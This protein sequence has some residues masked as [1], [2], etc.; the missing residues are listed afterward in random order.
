M[1]EGTYPSP[2]SPFDLY[3]FVSDADRDVLLDRGMLPW[4][5]HAHLTVR[6]LRPLSSV[7]LFG[8]QRLLGHHPLLFHL[9]SFLWWAAAALSVRSLFRRVLPPRAAL[10]ATFI[11]ALAPCH[12]LPLIWLA[13]RDVLVSIVFG[14]LALS[15]LV[16]LRESGRAVHAAVAALLFGVSLLGG[17]YALSFGGYALA[18]AVTGRKRGALWT[19]ALTV[20][21]FAVPAAAYL[22]VRARLGYGTEG[23]GMYHD[24]L[25]DPVAFLQRMPRRLVTLL[26]EGWLTFDPDTVGPKTSAWLLGASLLLGVIILAVPLRRTLARLRGDPRD[27]AVWLLVGSLLALAPVLA[28]G[29]A[30]RVLGASLVGVAAIVGLI[31]DHVWFPAVPE[32]PTRGGVLT[33]LVALALGFAHFV[34]GPTTAWVASRICRNEALSFVKHAAALSARIPEPASSEV[35]LVRGMGGSLFVLPYALDDT[36][37]PPARWRMLGLTGHML[38]IRRDARTIDV[39]VPRDRSLFP[40][41]EGDLFRGDGPHYAPGDTVAIPGM[42]VTI[43]E[44]GEAGP[45]RVRF[46][47][48]DALESPNR[49]WMEDSN[50]GIHEVVLPEPGFGKPFDP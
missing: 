3:N 23:S 24:P 45:H 13:N 31:L 19:R 26:G 30:P 11:F 5:T 28:V 16:R 2:R 40:S 6:F 15:A 17:E 14:V 35:V 1:I 10:M 33:G 25:R 47:F 43:L 21:S 7:L 41:G 29:P 38:V 8:E 22:V 36:G 50:D 46:E 9:F 49:V 37:A 4:W 42:R 32:P 18:L 27:H 44:V 48:P 20:L 39:I 12:A 34:H